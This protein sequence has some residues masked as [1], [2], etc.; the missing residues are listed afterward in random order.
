MIIDNL[1]DQNPFAYDIDT[2]KKYFFTSMAHAFNYHYN[3]NLLFK[4]WLDQIQYIEPKENESDFPF[5]P[6]AVFKY[7]DF[8]YDKP[9]S[10]NTVIHSS[11]TS[12]Q[13]KSKIRLDSITSK[14]QTRVLSKILEALIGKRKPYFI[15]DFPNIPLCPVI[16]IIIL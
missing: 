5:F 16:P 12:S 9:K 4:K 3:N 13:L 10:N 14:R 2:K 11:G 6:S 7:L 15:I 1:I 8:M